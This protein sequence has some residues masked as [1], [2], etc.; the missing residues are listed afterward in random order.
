MKTEE[1]EN[2]GD[3]DVLTEAEAS[4]KGNKEPVSSANGMRKAGNKENVRN[5]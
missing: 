2:G 5:Q 1:E 4:V 3:P